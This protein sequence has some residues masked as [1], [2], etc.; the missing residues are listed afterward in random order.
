MGFYLSLYYDFL[1]PAE[2]WAHT[3]AFSSVGM[4]TADK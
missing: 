4:L 2:G 3:H 1:I